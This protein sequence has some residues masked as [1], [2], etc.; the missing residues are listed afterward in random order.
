MVR[1]LLQFNGLAII[2]VVLFHAAGMGYVAMLSWAHRYL[3]AGISPSEQIG[4]PAYYYLRLV[5]QLVVFSI[6]A[7]LFV[8]GY[9][10]AVATGRNRQVPGWNLI[11]A[12]LKSLFIP[13]LIWSLVAYTLTMLAGGALTIREILTGLVVG[14]SNEA[15]YY[16]P[17]LAQFYLLSPLLVPFAKRNWTLLLLIC[18]L[19]QLAVIL[20]PYADYLGLDLPIKGQLASL[21]PKWFFPARMLWFPFG[22]VFGLNLTTFSSFL[23]RYKWFLI[24]IVLLCIPIGMLEWETFFRLSGKD[25]LAHRETLV[26]TIYS[27]AMILAF[28]SIQSATYL[29]STRLSELGVR[30]YGIYLIHNLVILYTAKVVFAVLPGLLGRPF[31]FQLLLVTA[32]LGG[33]LVLMSLVN[34]S[35]FRRYY[36]YLFG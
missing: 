9:F 7:F 13:Y 30:S 4:S 32:G 19:I 22:I 26:D 20:L 34:R 23:K 17:L 11:W 36:K 29:G 6:P 25:W 33:S 12:R 35:P 27:L 14:S 24:A 16:V 31:L 10:I 21:V 3:P 2:S 18:T 15:Y 5:D 28:L 8:S 1:R